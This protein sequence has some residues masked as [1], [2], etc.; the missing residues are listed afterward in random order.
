MSNTAIVPNVEI[1]I[2]DGTAA[3]ALDADTAK[4][5][6][7]AAGI[8]VVGL[9]K[10]TSFDG[11]YFVDVPAEFWAEVEDDGFHGSAEGYDVRIEVF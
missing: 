1:T 9:P 6:L 11:S 2:D 10:L 7:V 4:R 8:P 3:A 5:V